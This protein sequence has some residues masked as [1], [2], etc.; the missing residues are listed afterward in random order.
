MGHLQEQLGKR[1]FL[2][3]RYKSEVR[4]AKVPLPEDEASMEH[5]LGGT[6]PEPSAEVKMAH[7]FLFLLALAILS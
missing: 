7:P 6:S 2:W 5:V 4:V 1:D 3:L